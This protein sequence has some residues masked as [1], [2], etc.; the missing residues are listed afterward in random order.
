MICNFF[1]SVLILSLMILILFL[2]CLQD[3]DPADGEE[4]QD[5]CG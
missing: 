4:G 2:L 5:P 3:P 1:D